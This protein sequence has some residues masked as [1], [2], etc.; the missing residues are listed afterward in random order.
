MAVIGS[1][2]KRAGLLIGIVGFSLIAFIL[3]DLL[4]SNKSFISGGGN[5]VAIIGG[6]KI[7]IRDFEDRVQK[8][9]ENYKMR[10]E[11]EHLGG[12]VS[13]RYRIFIKELS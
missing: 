5:D 1:I 3:G 11:L 12:T 4:T 13:K 6:T 7:N 9:E 2:R 8:M 10:S